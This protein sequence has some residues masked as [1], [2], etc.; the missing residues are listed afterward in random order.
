MSD[1][2]KINANILQKS[3][4]SSIL[5]LFFNVNLIKKCE[6]L[7]I[8]IK[9]LDFINDINILIYNRFT[10]RWLRR[11]SK[12]ENW[13]FPRSRR[14]KSAAER[15]FINVEERI[16]NS[17]SNLIDKSKSKLTRKEQIINRIQN[18]TENCV[19]TQ[20]SK[21]NSFALEGRTENNVVSKKYSVSYQ[22]TICFTFSWCVRQ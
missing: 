21:S 20:K 17:D 1:I 10:E 6:A 9:V 11:K 16:I 3:F 14:P 22:I 12:F 8:K 19:L 15:E 18:S 2:H 13:N 7:R 5:F 4:I